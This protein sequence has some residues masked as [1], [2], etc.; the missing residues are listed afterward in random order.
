MSNLTDILA[1]PSLVSAWDF[2][3]LGDR[4]A[5]GPA[6]AVLHERGG[7]V[8]R[9]VGGV[10]SGHSAHFTPGVWLE[11]P[12]AV[13][14]QLDLRE[15]VSVLA[16]VWREPKDHPECQA[17]AGR[18]QET[19]RSRQYC[20]FIDLGIHQ[21]KDQAALHVSSIGGPSPGERWCMD[22]AIGASPVPL[23]SWHCIVGTF[24]GAEAHLYL[25]G[26]LDRRERFNPYVYPG[27]LHA[28]GS[29]FTV[30]SVHRGGSWGNWFTGRLGGLA[31]F[32]RALDPALVAAIS[33]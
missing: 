16:W 5:R 9:V 19:D 29:D 22:A 25:D 7:S 24:A 14:P 4:R 33:V 3:D 27:P 20:L 30:G 12:H 31:V 26:R 17:V 15:E 32:S 6:A 28:A 13:A 23:G 8:A 1:I 11:A 2:S 18:W 21:S 10:W